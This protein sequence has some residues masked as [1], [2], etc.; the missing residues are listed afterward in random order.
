M[1]NTEVC[2]CEVMK[3]RQSLDSCLRRLLELQIYKMSNA[4]IQDLNETLMSAK[5]HLEAARKELD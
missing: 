5:N 1:K 4:G 3:A 2:V